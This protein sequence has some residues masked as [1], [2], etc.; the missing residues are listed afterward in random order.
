M[1]GLMFTQLYAPYIYDLLLLL[2]VHVRDW[3]TQ[4]FTQ[5]TFIII[6]NKLGNA[7]RREQRKCIVL[8]HPFE[9]RNRLI[10]NSL[11]GKSLCNS[12]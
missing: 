5:M 10:Y 3:R 8:K 9:N 1:Y 6:E 2:C 4:N 11:A 12:L 7:F